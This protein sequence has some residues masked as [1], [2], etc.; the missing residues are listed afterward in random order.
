MRMH[1]LIHRELK[2]FFRGNQ[3]HTSYIYEVLFKLEKR[4]CAPPL[5]LKQ[6]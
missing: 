5:P 6:I 2:A 3:Y 4:I 1:K